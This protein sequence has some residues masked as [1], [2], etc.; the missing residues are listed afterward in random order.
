MPKP[1]DNIIQFKN[2]KHS[3][4]VPFTI[5]ADFE[6]MLQKIQTCQ[7]SDETSYTNAYQ[8]HVPNK[9]VYHIKYSNGNYKSPVE[10]SG[11]DA[12]KVFYQN[13]KEDALHIA[14]EFYDKV[15]P[16][17]PLTEQE[18]KEFKT[19]KNCHICER[20]LNTLSPLLVKKLV[21]TKTAIKYYECLGD[22]KSVN[23]HTGILKETEKKKKKRTKKRKVTGHDHLT[24]QFRGA[25]HSFCNLTYKNP[26]FIPNIFHNLAG[27]DA[28]LFIKDFG[29]DKQ[30]IK[31]IPSTEKKYIT[32][33]K[34]LKY[35][36]T[37]TIELRFVD[38]FK[39]LSSSLD[40]LTKNLGKDQFKELFKYFL[41]EHLNLITRKLAY[42]Y[43]YMDPPEKFK[44]PCL[45][46]IEEFYSSLN[47]ENVNEKEYQNAQEIWNKFN[48]KDL[49]EFRQLNNKIH[50]FLLADIMENFRD[51]SLK[52]YK[53]DLAWY[54][55]TTGFA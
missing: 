37:N 25:A 29:E 53:L 6:C 23:H 45:P 46:P 42:P 15:V 43:K 32:F 3:L 19:Q 2:Y 9:F 51:I 52:T 31:L 13:V 47:K 41:K 16:M 30:H 22:E 35:D 26:R 27:Y 28:H 17:K 38:L 8:K 49:L 33:S 21:T 36:S 14:K 10:Y 55:T 20:S 11:V 54:F 4:K 39:F 5:Y 44:E 7:P 40:K 24:G 48:I 12:P 1:Y 34:I 18:K 50:V